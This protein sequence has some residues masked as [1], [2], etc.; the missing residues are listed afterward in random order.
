MIN[1]LKKKKT[2]ASL[3][4][5]TNLTFSLAQLIIS[6]SAIG[7]VDLANFCNIDNVY[8]RIICQTRP[9]VKVLL[10]SRISGPPIPVILK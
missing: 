6:L 4:E 5:N 9:S 7:V 3:N 8:A 10:P 1:R 2:N